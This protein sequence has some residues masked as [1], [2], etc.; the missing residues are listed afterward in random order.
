M[1]SLTAWVLSFLGVLFLLLLLWFGYRAFKARRLQPTVFEFLALPDVD[2]SVRYIEQHPELLNTDAERFIEVL[3]NR[4]AAAGDIELFLSGVM[5]LLLM[6]QCREQGVKAVRQSLSGELQVGQVGAKSPAWNRAVEIVGQ[7]ATEGK[8][9]IPME[10]L[11][12]DLVGSLSAV[13]TLLRPFAD[14]K[15]SA[16][17]DEIQD[18]LHQALQQKAEGAFQSP[19]GT[20]NP[21]SSSAR[22]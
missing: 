11:D 14:E 12:E 21:P 5:H 6:K 2:A 1:A 7:L 3:L 15:T 4:V 9:H 16:A 22:A 20:P 10:E 13:M 17:M 8:A 19:S 18:G